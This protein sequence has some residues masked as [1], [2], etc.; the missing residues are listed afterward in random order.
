MKRRRATIGGLMIAV[1]IAAALLTAFEAGR[2]MQLAALAGPTPFQK[3]G[4][5]GP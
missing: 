1:V 2:R 4:G 5:L 3:H